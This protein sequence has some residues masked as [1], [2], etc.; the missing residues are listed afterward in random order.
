MGLFI[1]KKYLLT[2]LSGI[3]VG[4]AGF[5]LSVVRGVIVLFS[6]HG[7]SIIHLLVAAFIAVFLSGVTSIL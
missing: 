2:Q 5:L 3:V 7:G 6:I 1:P 4:C